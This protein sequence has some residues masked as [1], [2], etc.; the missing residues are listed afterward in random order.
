MKKRNFRYIRINGKVIM[1]PFDDS[2][3][4]QLFINFAIEVLGMKFI[5][6]TKY[7]IDLINEDDPTWGAEGENASWDGDRWVSSQRD[8]FNLG[9]DTL[10]LQNWKW[11]YFGLGELSDK[12]YGKYLKI[13]SG[14]YKNIYFRVNKQL[15]QICLVDASV[16]RDFTKIKFAFN[17]KVRNADE[18]EDWICIPKEYVRTFNRQPNGEWLENGKYWGVTEKEVAEMEKEYKQNRVN[19]VMANK[20][21]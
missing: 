7:G 13:H 1:D 6:G 12:N 18:P 20:N 17:R 11:W 5:S 2:E 14:Q 8:L 10:N 15:D 16:V 4:R 21:K 19:E 3:M 9:V